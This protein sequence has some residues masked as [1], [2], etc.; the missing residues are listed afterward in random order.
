[1]KFNLFDNFKVNQEYKKI[2]NI[3][4]NAPKNITSEFIKTI[5]DF[6]TREKIY[7][8][9]DAFSQEEFDNFFDLYKLDKDIAMK[10][11][12]SDI[13]IYSNKTVDLIKNNLDK[14]KLLNSYGVDVN[15]IF[16]SFGRIAEKIDKYYKLCSH[17]GKEVVQYLS[18]KNMSFLENVPC[19]LAR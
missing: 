7:I 17:Y 2:K 3:I 12:D 8:T 11:L 5:P 9:Y 10:T 13:I 15:F 1:M 16:N 6:N 19:Q 18:D 14:I 4:N